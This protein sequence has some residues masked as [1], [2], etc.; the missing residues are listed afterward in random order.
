MEREAS[1][2]DE[3]PVDEPDDSSIADGRDGSLTRR[4]LV[5]TGAATWATV[6]LAGCR[7]IT[8]PGV[9]EETD[10][11]APT[12]TTET[13]TTDAPGGETETDDGGDGDGDGD[14]DGEATPTETP[15]PTPTPAPTTTA[16]A[17]IG[18]FAPGMEVGLHVTVYDSATGE[19]LGADALDSVRVEFPTAEYGPLELNW[20]G[21]HER[22]SAETWGSKVVTDPTTEPGSYRYEVAVN[23][24]EADIETTV[25]GQF[26][27]V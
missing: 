14:G 16:C 13:T 21:N 15:T 24:D 18:Q 10:T 1:D 11:P 2:A 5:V 17:D 26:L 20:E 3:S 22:Y 19:P 12:V 9:D 23:G 4:S 25:T 8:D 27:I 6:G 7:Y